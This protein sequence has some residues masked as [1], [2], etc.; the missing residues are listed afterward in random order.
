MGRYIQTVAAGLLIGKVLLL[1]L[2][3]APVLA[4]QL[5]PDCAFG[6]AVGAPF[7]AYYALGMGAV[8]IGGRCRSM[9]RCSW[10]DS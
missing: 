7:P 8:C 6:R 10:P 2:V 9:E 1:S 5:E 3:V 4:K